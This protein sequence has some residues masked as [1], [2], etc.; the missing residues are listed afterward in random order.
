MWAKPTL[1]RQ[2]GTDEDI[3]ALKKARQD[4]LLV[5]SFEEEIVRKR[6][7][8]F[9]PDPFAANDVHAKIDA[10]LRFLM[11]NISLNM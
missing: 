5:W 4:E 7:R 8:S 9:L 1:V 11:P 10:I 3:N 6:Y 2:P